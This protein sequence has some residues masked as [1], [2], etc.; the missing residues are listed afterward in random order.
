METAD[1]DYHSFEQNQ[2][3]AE[4]KALLV[5]F[6][7]KPRQ[8]NAKTIEEGRPIFKDVEY[9]DIRIPGDRTGGVCRPAS[10]QDKQRFAPN[11][12]AFKQRIGRV[13]RFG[14]KYKV[15]VLNLL[16]KNSCEDRIMDI[17]KYKKKLGSI[18]D[19]VKFDTIEVPKSDGI[20]NKTLKELIKQRG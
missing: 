10:F 1:F 12:A 2:Q 4:D 7:V 15:I 17:L 20:T 8:D 11:Y 16:M 18:I 3:S 5:K 19:G 9:I 13:K 6:F 14:Q